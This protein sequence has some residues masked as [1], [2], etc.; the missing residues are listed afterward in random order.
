MTASLD[1][2]PILDSLANGSERDRD[3]AG[4]LPNIASM[5]RKRASEDEQDEQSLMPA[6]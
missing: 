4:L 1:L 5:I 6:T 2:I 3:D